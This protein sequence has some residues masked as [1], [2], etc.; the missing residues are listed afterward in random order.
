[1]KKD[2]KNNPISQVSYEPEADVLTWTVSTR[3]I[4]YA[5]EAG[6]LIVHFTKDHLPVLVEVL[7]ASQF[8]PRVENKI[9]RGIKFSIPAFVR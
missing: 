4:D 8:L 6:N 7:E 5:E 1:M 3:P 9:S 2:N